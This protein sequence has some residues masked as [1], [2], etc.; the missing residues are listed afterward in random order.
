MG[1]EIKGV[2]VCLNCG[3]TFYEGNAKLIAGVLH[4]PVCREYLPSESEEVKVPQDLL[5]RIETIFYL[6]L[7]TNCFSCPSLPLRPKDLRKMIDELGII[8][9]GA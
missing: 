3:S 4:C 5:L 1:D 2:K 8:R 7:R 6:L 9:R